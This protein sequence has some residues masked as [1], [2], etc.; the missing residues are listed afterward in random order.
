VYAE[1]M[2]YLVAMY[3]SWEGVKIAKRKACNSAKT[4][5]KG[6]KQYIRAEEDW[7]KPGK[8]TTKEIKEAMKMKG[9][10]RWTCKR[11]NKKGRYEV[12]PC[13][14]VNEPPELHNPPQRPKSNPHREHRRCPPYLNWKHE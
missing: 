14:D 3:V 11:T 10:W 12:R 2:T 13:Y 5:K 4:K 8:D 9:L 7:V 6:E 1:G